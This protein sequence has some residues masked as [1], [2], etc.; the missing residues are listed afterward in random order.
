MK[1]TLAVMLA[2]T[3]GSA[4]AQSQQSAQDLLDKGN[5][6]EAA[7]AAA[8]LNTSAGYALAARASSMGGSIATGAAAKS[9]FGKAQDFANK[10]IS[11]DA[12]NSDAYFEL[13]RAQGRLAQTMDPFSQL[14]LAKKIKGNLIKAL[15]LDNKLAG[16][17]VALGLWN[18]TLDTPDFKGAVARGQTGASRS[19]VAPNFERAIALEPNNPTHRL[20][21]GTALLKMNNRA[22]AKAQYEKAVALPASTYWEKRDQAIAQACLAKLK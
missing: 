5:W 12:N 15:T 13:A 3:L 9:L 20:E 18:A 1:Q 11:L 4:F 8:A 17:Y 6:Q 22:A 19:Q 10:A 21:Y 14:D 2:L 16:A 7:N